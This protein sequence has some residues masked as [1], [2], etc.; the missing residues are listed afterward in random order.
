LADLIER[1]AQA[2]SIDRSQRGK[3]TGD[4]SGPEAPRHTHRRNA[5]QPDQAQAAGAGLDRR[6]HPA[7]RQRH[8]RQHQQDRNQTEGLKS[9]RIDQGQQK[10]RRALS[11]IDHGQIRGQDLAANRIAGPGIDP[12]FNDGEQRRRGKT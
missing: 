3:R 7:P 9:A 10:L 8:Q 1:G 4:H 2:A 6:F 5:D 12:A 11:E